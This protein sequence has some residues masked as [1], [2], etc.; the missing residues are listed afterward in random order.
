M[1]KICIPTIWV[2]ANG[3]LS[4]H[5]ET[6]L[7]DVFLGRC[8]VEVSPNFITQPESAGDILEFRNPE[9]GIHRE[10]ALDLFGF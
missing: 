6:L 9:S 3:F 4:D 8:D 5:V 7:N 1:K 10:N 2:E